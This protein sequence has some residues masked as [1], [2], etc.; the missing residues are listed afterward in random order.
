[1]K[2]QNKLALGKR[3]ILSTVALCAAL[4]GVDAHAIDCGSF[5]EWTSGGVYPSGTQVKQSGRAY[6]ANWWS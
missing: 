4:V 2:I 5:A 3:L 6:K 1:M